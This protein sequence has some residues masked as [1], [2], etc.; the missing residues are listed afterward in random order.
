MPARTFAEKPVRYSSLQIKGPYLLVQLRR[1][2]DGRAD[3]AQGGAGP[4]GE[5]ASAGVM[6][7]RQGPVQPPGLLR[8]H[9]L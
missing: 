2:L 5:S 4:V 1:C 3:G 9:L 6:G 7:A 8:G